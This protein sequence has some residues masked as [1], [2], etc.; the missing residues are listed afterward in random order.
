M[1]ASTPAA[2]ESPIEVTRQNFRLAA[3]KLGLERVARAEKLRGTCPS[4][5]PPGSSFGNLA[6]RSNPTMVGQRQAPRG[7]PKSNHGKS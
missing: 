7:H 5:H 6:S 1:A 4:G 2:K 3:A